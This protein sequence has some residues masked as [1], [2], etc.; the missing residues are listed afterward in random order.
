MPNAAAPLSGKYIVPQ[1][2]L[3]AFL[4]DAFAFEIVH[5]STVA[6]EY[7]PALC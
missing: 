1:P 5:K 2:A 4:A 6:Y 7:H 3:V